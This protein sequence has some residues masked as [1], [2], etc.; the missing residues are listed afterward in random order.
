MYIPTSFFIRCIPIFLG[1]LA[2]PLKWKS[3]L[4]MFHKAGSPS[5]FDH[6]KGSHPHTTHN[7]NTLFKSDL[8]MI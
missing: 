8:P 7:T 3:L 2:Y 4:N 1:S 5:V 6:K